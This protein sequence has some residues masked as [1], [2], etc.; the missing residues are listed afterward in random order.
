MRRLTVFALGLILSFTSIAMADQRR[1]S[2]CIALANRGGMAYLYKASFRDP[3]EKHHVRLSY[4]AH[5]SF[6]IQTHD[7]LSAVTDYTGFIGNTDL[8]PDVVTMNHAHGTHWTEFPDPDIPHVLQGWGQ[9]GQPADHHLDLDTLLV[10]NVSTDIRRG[11]GVEPDGNSIF[12]FE[13]GGLCI[14]HLGH[15]HHEPTP[16]QYAA[17]GRMDVVMAAVDGS[18]TLD[19]PSMIRVLER[20]KARIVIPMHWFEGW[21]LNAFLE[22]MSR[23]YDIVNAGASELT[24][25]LRD[26]PDRPTIHVLT[27]RFLRDP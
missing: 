9:G 1:P 10:R 18:L 20:V 3:L 15:L 4:I 12:V 8:V 21:T 24:L 7:G 11:G 22:G 16:A 17:L 19:L 6:L 26:L 27:P 23:D 2:H 13:A 5:A 14:A 25:S